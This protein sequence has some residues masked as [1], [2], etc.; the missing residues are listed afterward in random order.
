MNEYEE[1]GDRLDDQYYIEDVTRDAGE[2]WTTD[3]IEAT[4]QGRPYMPPVDPAALPSSDQGADVAT[5]F[6]VSAEDAPFRADAPVGDGWIQEEVERVLREDSITG[7]LPL[8]VRVLDGTVYLHG[9]V[10]DAEDADQAETVVAQV[11][12]VVSVEDRTEV[13]PDRVEH[14]PAGFDNRAAEP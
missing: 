7:R 1:T 10:E 6:G 3:A 9:Y 5:G 8:T 4:E 11:P 14:T 2:G 12:G 13:D